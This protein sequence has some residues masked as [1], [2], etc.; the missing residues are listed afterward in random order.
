MPTTTPSHPTS[1]GATCRRSAKGFTLAELLVVIGII[2]L[3]VS[4]LVPVVSRVQSAG[5]AANTSSMIRAIDGAVQI[6]QQ[7]TKAYPGVFPEAMLKPGEKPTYAKGASNPAVEVRTVSGYADGGDDLESVTSTENLVLSLMG[8][9]VRDGVDIFYDPSAVGN[10]AAKLGSPTPGAYRAYLDAGSVPLS[11]HAIG[12]VDVGL[13]S[14]TGYS[15]TDKGDI[16]GRFTSEIVAAGDSTIPEFVDG[17]SEPMPILYLRALPVGRFASP[18]PASNAAKWNSGLIV[19]TDDLAN[20]RGVFSQESIAGYVEPQ[21]SGNLPVGSGFDPQGTY[22]VD[23]DPNS[24]TAPFKAKDVNE[25][26][27]PYYHGLRFASGNTGSVAELR[28]TM[29]KGNGE[30]TYPFDIRAYLLSP[31]AQAPRQADR[32]VL[33]SAGKDRV[34]GTEDDLTNFGGVLP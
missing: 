29:E 24:N 1:H 19:A 12:D 28:E 17:F 32:Y 9:L 25:G 5:Q 33:I 27:A 14:Q 22:T 31:T 34:Y 8:G 15:N 4:I 7:D 30:Y 13:S 23:G 11:S 20:D 21:G 6:Y 10:G 16:T 2:L 18:P 3:L 26:T